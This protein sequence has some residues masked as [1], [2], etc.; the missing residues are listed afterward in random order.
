MKVRNMCSPRGNRVPNQYIVYA[1]EGQYFQSYDSIVAFIP[2]NGGKIKLDKEWN[3]SRTTSKY[4]N[5]F[6]DEGIA[7]TRQ[8]IVDGVYEVVDLNKGD[9]LD[10]MV[11]LALNKYRAE[12]E[13]W[14]KM[15]HSIND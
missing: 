10:D 13:V 1:P 9:K 7:E 6:L 15:I 5:S 12:F 14:F 3:Y 8:K 11:W 4:R 2:E